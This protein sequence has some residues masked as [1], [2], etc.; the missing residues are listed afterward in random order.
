MDSSPRNP[1]PV[2]QNGEK[3]E[4]AVPDPFPSWF[5]DTSEAHL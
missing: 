5:I 2:V 4:V 3:G 1:S